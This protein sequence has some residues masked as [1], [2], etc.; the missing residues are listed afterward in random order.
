MTCESCTSRVHR[1]LDLLLGVVAVDVDLNEGWAQVD[2]DPE[3]VTLDQMHEA[4]KRTGYTV[5]D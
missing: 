4:I 1:S 3:K 2:Y 5:E